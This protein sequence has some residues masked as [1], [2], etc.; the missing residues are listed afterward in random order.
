MRI[1][2]DTTVDPPASTGHPLPIFHL[3]GKPTGATCNLD[4]QYCFFLPKETL[5]RGSRF[6][7]S[8]YLLEE[9]I[10]Q[11]MEG[12]PTPV[13]GYAGGPRL[14]DARRRILKAE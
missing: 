13:G 5:Y 4:C 8:G 7:V 9:Y 1:S 3:L 11:L 14:W 2:S 12:H 6:R 10:R